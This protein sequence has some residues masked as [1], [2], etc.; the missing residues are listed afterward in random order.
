MAY[1]PKVL[2]VDDERANQFLLDGLLR[3]NGYETHIATDGDE[4]L[5]ILETLK[6]DLILL[7]I[8]MPRMSGLEV[9][10]KI[11]S[12]DELNQ[13]PVIMVSAKTASQDIKI[14]LETGAVDYVKKP[15]EETELLARVKVGIRLK[16]EEDHL[17]EMISQREEFVRIISHDLRSPFI[18]IN[19]FAELLLSDDNLNSDQKE[20]LKQIIDSVEYS[21]EYFN[22]LLS[23]AKLEQNEI[24]L[25][26]REL[27]LERIVQSSIR[28]HERKAEKKGIQ[29][30]ITVDPA[31]TILGDEIFFRQVIENLLSNAIKFTPTGGK[32]ECISVQD[33]RNLRLIISDS[34]IGMP[35]EIKS[36]ELFSRK[37]MQS[38]RGTNNEKGT[39]IGLSICK[40]ILDAHGF[41]LAF[42]RNTSGGSDFIIFLEELTDRSGI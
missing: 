12:T 7:D 10:Q 40:K 20:S 13:I 29:L 18:A 5:R 8:M 37:N 27:N 16:I 30:I 22:K 42:Q 39:G 25:N 32:V 4:C 15:F 36:E 19:G 9:L 3:A 34:G 14:A 28:F 1:V 41:R 26:K 33:D 23:W 31:H 38:R 35:E 24:E 2:I 21:Q 11:I 6:P 17:R